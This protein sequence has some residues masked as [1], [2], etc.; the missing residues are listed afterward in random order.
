[1]CYILITGQGPEGFYKDWLVRKMEV[2]YN[3][4]H[5]RICE[6]ENSEFPF[7]IHGATST[8][9]SGNIIVCGG[10]L[11]DAKSGGD[12]IEILGFWNR[13]DCYVFQK[14]NGWVFLTRTH[15]ERFESMSIPID[16]GMIITGGEHY[17]NSTWTT[18]RSNEIVMLDGSVMEG[19]KLP[20]PIKTEYT[21]FANPSDLFRSFLE[22]SCTFPYD[23]QY[24]Y[25][26][27]CN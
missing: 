18:I 5:T 8:Y 19:P 7:M 13:K 6:R 15:Q 16:G 26:S 24:K 14:G 23:Q 1:M 3:N 9:T 21:T 2:I 27:F 4:G 10:L 25:I 17:L 11:G 12:R 22:F 20:M